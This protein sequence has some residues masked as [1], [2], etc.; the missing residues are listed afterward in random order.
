MHEFGSS[1]S[2][3]LYHVVFLLLVGSVQTQEAAKMSEIANRIHILVT[4]PCIQGTLEKPFDKF[5][6]SKVYND[7]FLG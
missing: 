2:F 5:G 3:C 1:L 6:I 4:I 7:C